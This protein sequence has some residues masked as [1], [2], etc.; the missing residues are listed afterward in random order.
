MQ[1]VS[2]EGQQSGQQQHGMYEQASPVTSPRQ[3]SEDCFFTYV[4]VMYFNVYKDTKIYH[5]R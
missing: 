5:A 1:L 4:F 2:V 3:N